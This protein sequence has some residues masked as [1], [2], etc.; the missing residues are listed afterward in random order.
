MANKVFLIGNLTKD[1]ELSATPGGISVAKF[2]LAV[3]RPYKN[4]DGERDVDFIN[5]VAWREL[6]ERC[7]QYL[8]KGKKAC[9]IG[10]LQIRKYEADD[11]GMRYIAEINAAEV[12]FLTPKSEDYGE[13]APPPAERREQ[14]SMPMKK[15]TAELIEDE[16][17]PF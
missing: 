4:Q 15:K 16:N 3:N 2:T 11:G 9:V 8:S 1:V 12:E 13:P 5:I 7:S 6:G 17:L 14:T 10:S